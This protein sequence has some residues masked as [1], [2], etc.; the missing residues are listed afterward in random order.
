MPPPYQGALGQV[1]EVEDLRRQFQL[2]RKIADA[3]DR[4]YEVIL[5]VRSLRSQLKSLA[6]GK[7]TSEL[8]E[9]VGALET[10]TAALEGQD[11]SQFL[12]TSE[13]RSLVRL[14]SGLETFLLDA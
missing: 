8:A 5:Q 3:L 12:S 9:N 1:S 14:N 2:D 6:Q 11:G 10:K 4:D 7:L 13:G